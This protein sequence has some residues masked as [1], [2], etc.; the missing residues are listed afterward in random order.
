MRGATEV[1][2]CRREGREEGGGRREEGVVHERSGGYEGRR[3]KPHTH[4][5]R[6]VWVWGCRSVA[7]CVWDEGALQLVA[8]LCLRL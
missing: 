3:E 5:V 6:D 7:W 1:S 2:T 8:R 4:R